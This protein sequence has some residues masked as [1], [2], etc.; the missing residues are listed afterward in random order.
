ML[1]VEPIVV[2]PEFG[3]VPP[4]PLITTEAAGS[5]AFHESVTG[6]P[7]QALFVDS[8][9]VKDGVVQAEC[10]ATGAAARRRLDSGGAGAASG[11]KLIDVTG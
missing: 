10:P 3:N 4:I 5:D 8:A 11:E 7:G 9:M 1:V 2:L 6:T